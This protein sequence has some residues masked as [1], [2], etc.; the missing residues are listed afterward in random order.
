MQ[1]MSTFD[2]FHLRQKP[3]FRRNKRRNRD[4]HAKIHPHTNSYKLLSNFCNRPSMTKNKFLGVKNRFLQNQHYRR[5][6]WSELSALTICHVNLRNL[7]NRHKTGFCGS[8]TGFFGNRYRITI[9]CQFSCKYSV[10]QFSWM[11]FSNVS[12]INA[13]LRSASGS[14][15]T[16]TIGRRVSHARFCLCASVLQRCNSLAGFRILVPLRILFGFFRFVQL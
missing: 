7:K 9:R 12:L 16:W 2:V 1:F 3:V 6:Q 5:D 10:F 14:R 15:G 4:Q 8:E 11:N 13:S